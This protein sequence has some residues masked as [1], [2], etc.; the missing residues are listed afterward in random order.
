M[1]SIKQLFDTPMKATLSTF[2]LLA[3]LGLVGAGSALAAGAIAESS[4]IGAENAQNFAFA[5]AGIDPVAARLDHSEFDFE[6]GQFV[7]EVKFVADGTEYEYWIKA[8]DGSIVKK[9]QEVLDPTMAGQPG[10]TPA[11]QI[12]LEEAKTAAL[13]DAGLEA[14]DVRFGEAHAD[15]DDGR[16]LY[17]VEFFSGDTKYEYEI[18]AETGLVW[19]KSKETTKVQAPASGST[20]GSSQQPVSSTPVKPESKPAETQRP[21]TQPNTPTQPQSKP[22]AAAE[23][24]LEEA[25]SAALADAGLS[26]GEVSFH[27]AEKDYDDGVAYYDV[28]FISGSYKYEY[29]VAASDGRIWERDKEALPAPNPP[30]SQTTTPPASSGNFS[31]NQ[32]GSQA[33]NASTISMEQARSIAASHAG[34]SL[35]QLSFSKSKLEEEDGQ[36]VYEIEFYSGQ[37]EYEYEIDASNGNILDYD[38]EVDD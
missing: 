22:T 15:L 8:D 34:L 2:G 30:A 19:S 9:K 6:Q 16:S 10:Q 31:G 32:T 12:S 1:K 14:G 36:M 20:T 37:M 21:A 28:E 3:L 4:A 5:D 27:K 25:K 29:E 38:A 26:A 18:D 35:D 17:E 33:G 7:Y 13:A 23:L 24:S 11:A